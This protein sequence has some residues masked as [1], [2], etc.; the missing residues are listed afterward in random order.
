[1]LLLCTRQPDDMDAKVINELKKLPAEFAVTVAKEFSSLDRTTVR[2][3]P[4]YL[5]GIARRV[6]QNCKTYE[7]MCCINRTDTALLLLCVF[8]LL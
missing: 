5:C 1:M 4:N 6:A 8:V 7:W 3:V 2:N